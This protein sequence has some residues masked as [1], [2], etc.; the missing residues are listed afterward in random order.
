M[1]NQAL[2]QSVAY[3]AIH[4]YDRRAKVGPVHNMI[5]STPSD[6]ASAADRR[7]VRHAE[8]I[9]NRIFL[10]AVVRGIDDRNVNGKIE[11]G[12]RNRRLRGSCRLRRA[13]LLLPRPRTGLPA[14]ASTVPLFDF[15]PTFSYRTPQNPGAAPC[16]TSCTDF[17]WEIYLR[18]FRRRSV[19][20]ELPATRVRHR[21]RPGRRR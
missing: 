11:P 21:E 10:D 20:P 19:S 1:R 18:G 13:E 5:A 7:G 9:F 4:R 12:E 2:A 6:P 8:Y 15:V 16:P 17:G 3:D 14:P